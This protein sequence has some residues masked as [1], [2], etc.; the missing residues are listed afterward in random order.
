M[1]GKFLQIKHRKLKSHCDPRPKVSCPKLSG[2]VIS[3]YLPYSSGE[4]LIE[5]TIIKGINNDH[6]KYFR[7]LS[8][9]KERKKNEYT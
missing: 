1:Y 8:F 3:R 4:D 7:F 5:K 2:A 9:T 6:N